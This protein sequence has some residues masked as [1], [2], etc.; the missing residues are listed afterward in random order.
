MVDSIAYGESL[1]SDIRARNDKLRKQAEKDAR[2]KEWTNMAVN[3][4]KSV[5]TDIYAEKQNRLMQN[6]D[7]VANKLL[8]Q[9]VNDKHKAFAAEILE[10]DKVGRDTYY[11]DQVDKLMDAQLRDMY[12]AQGTYNESNF[13]TLKA[14]M[15]KG[16]LPQYKKAFEDREAAHK[17]YNSTGNMDSYNKY[18]CLLY[19]SPSPRDVEESRMPSSA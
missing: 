19:T 11:Y 3:I 15:V 2:K 7:V 12:G 14:K 10:A 6:E 16:Y 13:Q 8:M 5:F 4:G 17:S 1:L 9:N 18:I